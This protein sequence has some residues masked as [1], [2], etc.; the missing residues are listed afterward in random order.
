[1]HGIGQGKWPY[2]QKELGAAVT[3]MTAI[4]SALDPDNIMNPGKII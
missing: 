3:Y 2:L 1:M 4:K